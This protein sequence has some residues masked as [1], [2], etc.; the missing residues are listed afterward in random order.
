MAGC[1][2]PLVP[3]EKQESPEQAQTFTKEKKNMLV[4]G[5][6]APLFKAPAFFLPGEIY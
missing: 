5:K 4:V 3:V 2:R 1:S 6:P